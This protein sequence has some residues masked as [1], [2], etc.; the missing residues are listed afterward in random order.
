MGKRRKQINWSEYNSHLVNRGRNF[1]K[2][3]VD[4]RTSLPFMDE[5]LK[6]MNEGKVGAPY[7]YADSLFVFLG[8]IKVLTG[9]SYRWL[10]GFCT[11]FL[12][13]VPDY[14]R[15][16]RRINSLPSEVLERIHRESVKKSVKDKRV[17]IILDAT[18]IRLNRSYIW[19]DEKGEKHRK[20]NW[21]KLH[22]G[23]VS[24]SIVYVKV[25][26]KTEQEGSSK[27]F[28]NAIECS[29][30]NLPEETKI[31]RVYA[32]GGYDSNDN[33]D[34]CEAKGIEPIIKI[35]ESTIE[36]IKREEM[37]NE[38]LLLYGRELEREYNCRDKWAKKQIDWERFVEEYRYGKR[39][40]V[41]GFIGAFKHIFGEYAYSKKE[42]NINIEFKLKT[43]AWN[44]INSQYHINIK[45]GAQ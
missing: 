32:D 30:K 10:Q 5:E 39:G 36:K 12:N 23:I 22:V 16:C 13:E 14:S 37:I 43:I 15:I 42:H 4:F 9:V 28:R 2:L 33:F 34:L 20:R 18:G 41:E 11:F 26:D 19:R 40:G 27:E 7:R 8:L 21:K 3:L 17:E 45:I 44:Y 35:R 38:Q 25:I 31:E 24:G 6:E 1:A 29:E